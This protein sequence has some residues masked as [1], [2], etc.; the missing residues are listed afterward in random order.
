MGNWRDNL[1]EIESYTAGEQRSA[2]GLVKLNTN[3]NP[4]P[5]S[6]AVRDAVASFDADALVKYPDPNARKLTQAFAE[7][8]G[9]GEDMVMAGNGSDEILAFAFRAFFNSGRPVLFPDVTYS[10]YPVWCRLF[11][12]DFEE[13]PLREDF[14]ADAEDY[15]CRNG[16]I[17]I[18]NPNAPTGIAENE[19][20]FVKILAS[21]RDS[22]VVVDEAYV[23]FG[24]RSILP[25]I[26]EYDN[27][28]VARTL[29]KSRS[30][31][32]L[33][34]GFGFGS[35]E[36]IAAVKAVKNSFNSYTVGSFAIS[37][38]AAAADDDDYYA[39]RA[40]SLRRVRSGFTESLRG[41]GFSVC[42]SSANFVFVTH[43]GMD[44]GD[45]YRRLGERDILVRWFDK[46]RVRNHLRVTIGREEEMDA[47]LAAIRDYM[48]E[49]GVTAT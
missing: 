43:P 8:E 6:P 30:L 48:D 47:L 46:P 38:G 42:D 41:L 28:F 22:V 21:N 29:S 9:I 24:A 7:K 25:L 39:E 19:D 20:F 10:F 13:I 5:P 2:P 49:K 33:R 18:P 32:G 31:A 3:E 35:P 4:F 14:H 15:N 34:L 23:G 11:G 27:L 17:V 1:I 40:E 44:A 36:L 37:V 12:I 26:K 16:G 45:L